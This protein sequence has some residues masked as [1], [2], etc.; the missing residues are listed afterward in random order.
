M[1]RGNGV[2][3][4]ASRV[5][6]PRRATA[7]VALVSMAALAGSQ[8]V[9]YRA[10]EIGA[11]RYQGVSGVAAPPELAAATPRSAHGDWILAICGVA[12][13][14]LV[15]AA[16]L[17]R[18]ALAR[19]LVLLGAGALAIALAVDRPH[20]LQVGKP[21]VEYQ[22]AR[23]VLSSGYGAEITAA[24]TLAFAGFVLP[25]QPGGAGARRRRTGSPQAR[26]AAR[27]GRR[28]PL[29]AGRAGG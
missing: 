18:P 10:V 27:P 20:G 7:L 16:W 1:M 3:A 2:L 6:N 15:A 4:T 26:S 8:L 17:R 14:I 21:G 5:L 22:G 19:F 11:S 12:L 9:D 29:E 13:L 28:A 25:L 23:A 24:A